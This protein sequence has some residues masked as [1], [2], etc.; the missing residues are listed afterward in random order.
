MPKRRVLI[1]INELLRGGAQRIV[2]DVAKGLDR[3]EYELSVLHLKSH[4]NFGAAPTLE[5]EIRATGTHV[6]SLEGAPRASLREFFALVALMRRE[7]PDIVHTFLPYA[8]TLGRIAARLAGVPCVISTQCNTR[9]AYGFFGFW[10]DRLTLV[11]ASAWVAASRGIE[12]TYARDAATFSA[13]LWKEGR[14]HFTVA[15]GVDLPAFDARV[16]ATSKEEKRRE[17]GVPSNVPLVMMTARLLNWKGPTDVVEAVERIPNAHLALIGWG[18]LEGALRSYAEIHGFPERLHVLGARADIPELLA[19]ADIYVQAHRRSA[20]GTIW[21]GPNTAQMEACAAKVPSVSTKVPLIEDLIEDGVTGKLA[22]PND[23]ADI[24]RA[25]RELLADPE[26][27]ARL[28]ARARA[29]VE[30][31]FSTESMVRTHEMLYIRLTDSYK[32]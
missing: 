28:V 3:A 21:M 15:A 10:A 9:V 1:V 2:A 29:R 18:P 11:F 23:A 14:R 16:A 5:E 22:A 31:R 24:R 7:K 6:L 13:Q 32:Q 20:D 26:A 4:R 25:I 19:A 12:L 17:I 30:E 27:A 8:G